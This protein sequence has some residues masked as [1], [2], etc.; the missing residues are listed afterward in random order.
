MEWNFEVVSDGLQVS[1]LNLRVQA[2]VHTEM[3]TV[4]LRCSIRI[5]KLK[6][7]RP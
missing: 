2:A 3:Y 1:D 4:I 6:L 5:E 7:D